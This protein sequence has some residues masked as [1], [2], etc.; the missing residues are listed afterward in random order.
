MWYVQWNESAKVCFKLMNFTGTKYEIRN[1]QHAVIC[2]ME[3]I[4]CELHVKPFLE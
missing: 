4:L 2:E 3:K 1:H